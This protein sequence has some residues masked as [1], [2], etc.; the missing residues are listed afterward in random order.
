M[1]EQSTE[2]GAA[3]AAPE[4][5][6]E[7]GKVRKPHDR[8]WWIRLVANLLI[9]GGVLCIPAYYAGTCACTAIEQNRL[10]DDLEAANPQLAAAEEALVANGFVWMETT[11]STIAPA[12]TEEQTTTTT[13]KEIT[14]AEAA[15]AA[16]KAERDAK[17]AAFR[18]AA[19]A[20]E[21]TVGKEIGKPIGKIIISSIG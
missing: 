6:R 16:A 10:R 14:A 13:V 7:S 18:A 11:T 21:A 20:F 1:N 2:N 9:V 17:L 12:A 19:D 4:E 5:G 3:P 8:R 15:I